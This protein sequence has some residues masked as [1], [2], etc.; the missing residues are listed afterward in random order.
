MALK[1]VPMRDGGYDLIECHMVQHELNPI[2]KECI[3]FWPKPAVLMPGL[4]KMNA[5]MRGDIRC[6][7]TDGCEVDQEGYCEHAHP[8]WLVRIGAIA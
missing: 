2:I 4:V 5:M 3:K 1:S 8:S 7:A 6:R